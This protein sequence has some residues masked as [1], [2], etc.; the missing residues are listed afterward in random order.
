MSVN[1]RFN[2]HPDQVGKH[3]F[4]SAS[5]YSW[6]NY[7]EDKLEEVF[8][9]SME[10]QRGTDLHAY[11]AEAI[12]LRRK[13]PRTRDT[14]NMFINDVIGY[15]MASEQIL[16]Y[17]PNVF[18][19]A[20]AISFKNGLLRIFD[21]KTGVTKASF[22]QLLVYAALFCLEYDI[23][24]AEVKFDLRI[25]Q[26]NEIFVLELENDDIVHDVINIMGKIVK[27]DRRINQIRMEAW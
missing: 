13:Q 19:T 7:D 10:A 27:F 5:K 20:D 2:H 9:N 26:S 3:A 21:L 11:A 22:T 4:L 18:G 24:P 23:K 1:F 16:F 8:R 12:R 17:S 15:R 25:Y 6:T 14:V